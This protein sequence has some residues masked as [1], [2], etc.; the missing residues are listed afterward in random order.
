MRAGFEMTGCS[1]VIVIPNPVRRLVMPRILS[2]GMPQ[3]R[4]FLLRLGI[5]SPRHCE[6]VRT[7]ARQSALFGSDNP[8]RDAREACDAIPRLPPLRGAPFAQGGLHRAGLCRVCRGGS[9]PARH[10]E[11]HSDAAIRSPLG[12]GKS[13]PYKIWWRAL[14]RSTNCSL[15]RVFVS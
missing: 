11:E 15:S 1:C 9:W 7:L 2:R 10:C 14:R 6:P 4:S 5:L 12:R 3:K 13:L 8:Q